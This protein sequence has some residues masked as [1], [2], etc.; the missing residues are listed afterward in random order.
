M[1]ALEAL[2]KEIKTKANVE[3]VFFHG[4]SMGTEADVARKIQRSF[5]IA[6]SR[7]RSS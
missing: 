2:N 3:F 6:R 5:S 1:N 4:G 7:K